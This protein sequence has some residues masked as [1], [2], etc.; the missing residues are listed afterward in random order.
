MRQRNTIHAAAAAGIAVL[1][2]L[3][4][5]ACESDGPVMKGSDEAKRRYAAG[6][7]G[8]DPGPEP[9]P[10]DPTCD[11]APWDPGITGEVAGS[12]WDEPGYEMTCLKIQTTDGHYVLIRVPRRVF[13]RCVENAPYPQCARGAG[14]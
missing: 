1:L 5:A 3:G 12:E 14:R 13:D 4:A 8:G 9:W 11:T 7:T 2:A 10:P 6:D